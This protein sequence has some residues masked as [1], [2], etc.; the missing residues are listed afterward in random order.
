LLFGLACMVAIVITLPAAE[1]D[2]PASPGVVDELRTLLDGLTGPTEFLHPDDAFRLILEPAGAEMLVARFQIA[3]RYYLYRDKTSF[4]QT[5]GTARLKPYTLPPGTPKQD[6]Y[7]GDVRVYLQDTDVLL[8]ISA[9]GEPT[10]GS[11]TITLVARYQGCAEDGICYPPAQKTLSVAIPGSASL[12]ELSSP[13][14]TTATQL[15]GYLVVAF[16]AGFLL[17]FTPCVLPLIPILSSVIAGQQGSSI[18]RGRSGALAIAYVL[19]TAVT[20][21]AVGAVAGA[22]GDQLQAYFQNIWAIGAVSLILVLMALSMFGLYTIQMPGFLQSRL[23]ERSKI[24]AGSTITIV[25]MLGALSALVVGACVSPLLISI[26][27]IAILK[28]DPYLGAALMFSMALGMGV[29]LTAVGFGAG[30][31]L[32][33]AGPW[34]KRIKHFFGLM[35]LGVAIYLLD[36]IQAVP[37]LL[38]W[39]ALLLGAGIYLTA[40][41]KSPALARGWRYLSKGTSA[42]LIAWG[43]LAMIGSFSGNREILRPVSISWLE[44]IGLSPT[45][46]RRALGSEFVRIN[47][48]EELDQQ[49]ASARSAGKPVLLD[50]YA[51]W[52]TDCIRMENST[53]RDPRVVAALQR[54]VRLQ[55]DVTD[56]NH[57]DNRAVKRRYGVFGP[58]AMLFFDQSGNE[59]R[60]KR[61]YG[62]RSADEFLIFLQIM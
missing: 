43:V 26:L 44:D 62:Y 46:S 56:P 47:G 19:G 51:D 48:L 5:A 58:P 1:T 59:L 2:P 41:Q 15:I 33:Q 39:A 13:P 8:P 11:D 23:V 4:E 49:L 38:L 3:K 45:Q 36:T 55:I 18:Q 53:F 25:F 30:F 22:T 42:I 28:G 27:S 29:V 54:F 16:G 50:Y 7:F 14:L 20:Y 35:L 32:P 52:C 6:E 60:T 57:Q 10:D 17:S 21:T 31:L 37:I 9:T 12:L 24:L 61:L 40:T 34:M